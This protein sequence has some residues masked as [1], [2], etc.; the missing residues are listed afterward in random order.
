[1]GTILVAHPGNGLSFPHTG[2]IQLKRLIRERVTMRVPLSHGRRL[3]VSLLAFGASQ[4]AVLEL[5]AQNGPD[6]KGEPFLSLNLSLVPASQ[7]GF[8]LDGIGLNHLSGGSVSGAGDV[9]GDGVADFVTGARSAN[10]DPLFSGQSYVIFGNATGGVV[11]LGSIGAAGF[12]IDGSVQGESSGESVSGAGDVNGDGLDDVVIGAFNSSVVGRAVVV[13]GKTGTTTVD[14]GALGGGG[15]NIIGEMNLSH[16]GYSV[17]G[18]GDVNGDGLDDVIIGAKQA[19][20]TGDPADD[21]TGISYVVFGKDFDTVDV[22]LSSLGSHGFKIIGVDPDDLSGISVS[23]AGDVNGDGLADV[24]IGASRAGDGTF[25]GEAYVVFGKADNT[26]VELGS[27]GSGGF[28]I[29]AASSGDLTGRSVAGAGDVNGDG[30]ADVIVGAYGGD[31][32]GSSSGESFVVFGKAGSAAVSLGALGAGGFRIDGMAIGDQAGFGVSGAGDVNRDGLADVIVG[33]RRADPDSQANAGETYVIFGKADSA[34]VDLRDQGNMAFEIE[35]HL[36]GDSSGRS[37]SSAGDVNGD[38]LADIMIGAYAATAGDD[39]A[40]RSYVLFTPLEQSIFPSPYKAFARS[41]DAPNLAIGTTGDGGNASS[42]DSRC[43]IDFDSGSGPGL[44]GASLQTVTIADGFLVNNLDGHLP[45]DWLIESDRT[46]FGTAEVVL[47]YTDNELVGFPEA[48][49][50]VY[51]APNDSGP[52]SMISSS[53]NMAR[54][55]FAF[56]TTTFGN[57]ALATGIPSPDLTLSTPATTFVNAPINVTATF[58]LEVTGFEESDLVLTN[59]TVSGFGQTANP[60]VYEFTLEPVSEGNFNVQV[61][62]NVATGASGQGNR[63]SNL[64]QR[65]FDATQP[66]ATLSTLATDPTNMPFVVQVAFNEL[67]SGL[68]IDEF[69][70]TNGT[71]DDLTA[72]S[73]TGFDLTITPDMHGE[74]SVTLPADSV[75]DS[76]GNGNPESNTITIFNDII[77][78]TVELSSASPDPTNTFAIIQAEFSDTPVGFSVEDVSATNATVSFFQQSGMPSIYFYRLTAVSDG[79]F[80]TFIGEGGATDDLGNPNSSSNTLML[81]FDGTAPEVTISTESLSVMGEFAVDVSFGEGVTGFEQDDV[82]V[83]NGTLS[84]FVTITEGLEYGFT[85]TPMVP[86]SVEIS[87]PMGAASDSAG[88][89]NSPSNLL[90]V[91]FLVEPE[92][93]DLWMLE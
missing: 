61:P 28:L 44:D 69:D 85:V 48:G 66:S 17:S 18:A 83:T 84:G 86:G 77:G 40:G 12:T 58:S 33:A 35:G 26:T 23:G 43:W 39:Y 9:N 82:A 3:A 6:E 38:G 24:I 53:Q 89:D 4:F 21:D 19:N 62:V 68:M 10:D 46:S 16:T 7:P 93:T 25:A 20:P 30:L 45:L 56:N 71:A 22:D 32:N 64:I 41:D 65:S 14:L 76:A 90:V 57:F 78:P 49:L 27:L 87:V 29:E 51:Q 36:P 81:R 54:N 73:S 67:V 8:R 80:S 1:M 11:D 92:S 91:D 63:P 42:P 52:W 55:E 59:A 72:T 70:V 37:V 74:V 34:T 60:L 5:C 50:N 88:N 47:R 13:F 15:F 75:T 31:A 79:P 2:T